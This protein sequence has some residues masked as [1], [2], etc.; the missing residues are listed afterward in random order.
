MKRLLRSI[1]MSIIAGIVSLLVQP[2]A[3]L[4]AQTIPL[5]VADYTFQNSLSNSIGSGPVLTNI[6]IGS[7]TFATET[8]NSES[9][10]VLQFPIGN[11][12]QLSPTT[13]LIANDTYTIVVYFRFTEVSGYRKIID[14]S[15]GLADEGLYNLDNTLRYYPQSGSSET[16]IQTD[17]YVQVVLTRDQSGTVKGYADGTEYVSFNDTGNIG[18]ITTANVLRF[19]KDDNVQSGEQATGA[20]ARIRLFDTVLTSNQIQSLALLGSTILTGDANSDGKISI[21]D[22][23][24]TIRI[25]VGKDPEPANG[26]DIFMRVDA[27]KDGNINILD[28]IY[29][30]NTILGIPSKPTIL[31]VTTATVH[32]DPLVL[33]D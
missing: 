26:S 25:A 17:Q 32:F 21:L 27:N 22:I 14:V 4:Q 24:S 31:P 10:T 3:T 9:R 5:P 20:V 29:T 6:G 12:L 28:V 15:N 30:V 13:G 7:S 23:I 11:G 8:V 1:Y 2:V 16:P 19:F 18:V 33:G